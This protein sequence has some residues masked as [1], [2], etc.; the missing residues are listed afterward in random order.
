M[1]PVRYAACFL[2]LAGL[3]GAGRAQEPAPLVLTLE[4][5]IR[6]ALA[7]NPFHRASREK[8]SAAKSQVNEAASRFFPT[9]DGQGLY[10][11]DEKVFSLEFPSM[12][13]GEPPT[14]MSLDFTKD[15]Q[16][17]LSLA[18]PLYAGGRLVSGFKSAR[19]GLDAARETVRQSRQETVFNVKKAFYGY[20]FARKFVDV[21][22]EA[23]RLAEKHFINVKN[24]Y[25]VG[26][27]SKFDLLRSEVQ[28]ANL[29]P[30]LIR[31]RNGLQTAGL[32]LKML[33]GLEM[34]SPIEVRGELVVPPVQPDAAASEVRALAARPELVQLQ[35]QSRIAGEMVKIARAAALPSLAIAGN[36][37][38]WADQFNFR[39]RNWQDYYSVNLVLTI[40]L[41]NGFQVHSQVGQSQALLKEIEW[42]RKG[43]AETVKFEVQ[44][45][46]LN[47]Q[48]AKESLLSQEKSVEQA[49]EAVRIAELNYSE[50]LA[51][52]LD[53]S[54]VQ[55]AL[56]QAR[57]NYAQALYD[58]AVSAAELDKATG[59]DPY[60]AD[61]TD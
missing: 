33:L 8:I 27:A 2:L 51:T 38:F 21:S 55:V 23:V 61:E 10:T 35:H 29:K 18:V 7:Q 22:E 5:S 41:L 57:T 30:Q 20:L 14:R 13:P 44:Q 36:F 15:Y 19:Y 50:G 28:V 42:N 9:L 53:V 48:Q 6:L 4:D 52:T 46:L 43:L 24:L 25:E 49:E 59:A 39:K 47:L 56:A 54:S 60:A 37:N 26:M 32:G 31:A 12:I 11:L 58:Y 16:F 1:K 45:A 17:S 3:A 40:P 34:D